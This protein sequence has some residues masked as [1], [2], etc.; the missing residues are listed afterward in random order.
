[1]HFEVPK[2]REAQRLSV[3]AW[4]P[5]HTRTGWSQPREGTGLMWVEQGPHTPCPHA[6]QWCLDMMAVK[7]LEHWWHWVMSWSG[8]Q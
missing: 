5:S 6:L 4:Q 7:V 8:T 3:R 1:M 2:H